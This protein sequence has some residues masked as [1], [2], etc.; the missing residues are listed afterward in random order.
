M[1]KGESKGESKHDGSS[2]GSMW[3]VSVA[4]V[5]I[6]VIVAAMVIHGGNKTPKDSNP[7]L[8]TATVLSPEE[9]AREE[10]LSLNAV[11]VQNT[12]SATNDET[13]AAEV[14]YDSDDDSEKVKNE[15]PQIDAFVGARVRVEDQANGAGPASD[16]MCRKATECQGRGARSNVYDVIQNGKWSRRGEL[17]G[18]KKGIVTGAPLQRA[19]YT[20][21]DPAMRV[22]DFQKEFHKIHKPVAFE[23]F[24]DEFQTSDKLLQRLRR[25]QSQNLVATN[26]NAVTMAMG[27]Q[28]WD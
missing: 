3:M 26:E 13:Q 4:A 17:D 27:Q 2:S 6:V 8:R 1:G 12:R 22:T 25:A 10:A 15:D 28:N 14:R 19:R 18:K 20:L 16:H 9:L 24:H 11:R 5:V 7:P 21:Q 23:L